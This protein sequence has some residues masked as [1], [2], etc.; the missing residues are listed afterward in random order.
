[1]NTLRDVA[2]KALEALE[3]YY[4][5][6][7]EESDAEAITTL[8]TALMSVPDEAELTNKGSI[9]PI[10]N[11]HGKAIHPQQRV[12]EQRGNWSLLYDQYQVGNTVLHEF[13]IQKLRHDIVLY[14]GITLAEAK[15]RFAEKVEAD[16]E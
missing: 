3:F 2:Q 16:N 9:M 10:T 12:I 7:G 8:R 5:Q 6:H 4:D 14:A 11:D 15:A 1:M 13:R